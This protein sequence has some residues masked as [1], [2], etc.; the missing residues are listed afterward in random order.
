MQDATVV[1]VIG[2]NRVSTEHISKVSV[3]T[4]HNEVL[5]SSSCV[6]T[7]ALAIPRY[8]HF[9]LKFW[10]IRS[11]SETCVEIYLNT[12]L[13]ELTLVL[14]GNGKVSM[15]APF[16]F[17]GL[18]PVAAVE[19]LAERGLNIIA[20]PG[21]VAQITPKN[22]DLELVLAQGIADTVS[23]F[24]VKW[25]KWNAVIPPDRA[26]V[27]MKPQ[28]S[29]EFEEEDADEEPAEAAAA[30]AGAEEGEAPA[31]E[32]K[33]KEKKP[34]EEKKPKKAMIAILAKANHMVQIR[35]S[36]N[37]DE[38]NLKAIDENQIH[39]HLF[40]MFLEHSPPEVQQRVKTA[41]SFLCDATFYFLKNLRLFS[42]SQ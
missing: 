5:F 19:F 7:F 3:D 25:S 12:Q 15:E 24:H 1:E 29:F 35:N 40:P 10:E 30:A 22:A 17:E 26:L 36:E 28:V 42:M 13:V 27:L 23:G 33:E 41:P 39:Q 9:P 34:P 32:E 2:E 14:D 37:E 20:P 6:G 18:T 31:A 16:Q 8:S 11:L 38:C 21:A 4:D